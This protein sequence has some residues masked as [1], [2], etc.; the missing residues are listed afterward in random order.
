MY[1]GVD[2]CKG[3]WFAIR[4]AD[5]SWDTV[6]YKSMCDLWEQNKSAAMILVDI[7]IGLIDKG[8]EERKCDVEARRLLGPGRASSVF[9]APCRIA[10]TASI[11]E[12]ASAINRENTGRGLS[13]QSYAIMPKIREVDELLSNDE[14]A[15]K[16]IREIHPEICF[17]ALNDKK[18][19]V[20]NKKTGA[21]FDERR[22]LLSE[23]YNSSDVI[24][25]TSL[26][27]FKRDQTARDDIV[28]A[29]VGAITAL[30]GYRYGIKSIP[31]KHEKNKKGRSVE[32]VF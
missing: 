28:D 4:L 3:G 19:M 16:R 27:K 21:G 23:A 7:P 25:K 24:I 8:N 10:L 31:L 2:G 17:W 13:K 18:P 20:Y 32:M 22:R 30:R 29:L 1:V 15:R 26:K 12:E 9:P 5:D 11:Y 6:I 14:S